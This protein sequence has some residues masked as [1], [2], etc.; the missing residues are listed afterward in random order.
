[1][2]D[3]PATDSATGATP[4]VTAALLAYG[5]FAVAGVAGLVSS[6]L[7]FIAPLFHLLGI[8]GVIVCY[9]KRGDARGTWV[10]SHF[11][12]LIRTFWFS[13]LWSVIGWIFFVVL[14]II[15]IGPIIAAVIWAVAFIWVLYRVI[16]GYLLFNDSKAIPG[17]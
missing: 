13:M 3:L 8:V 14:L 11:T 4:P 1:M 5:L 12:W 15:L 7:H 17:V 9:V 10:A 6:G 16:R 2:A